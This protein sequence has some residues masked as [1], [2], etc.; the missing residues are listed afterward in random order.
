M[1]KSCDNVRLQE[2]THKWSEDGKTYTM[3]NILGEQNWK[4]AKV[5]VVL[6][7]HWDT[8]PHASEESDPE[9]AK[10]PILGANDGASGVAVLLELARAV[11]GRLPKDLGVLYL[12]TDGEDLGPSLEEMFLGAVYFSKHLPDPKPNYGILLDM[13]GDRELKIPVEPNSYFYAQDL[14][15]VFYRL[16]GGAGFRAAFPT[17][18]GPTIEDDHLCLNQVGVPTMDLIDFDY[19]PSHAWWHTGEDTVD[20]CSA[21]SLGTVGK[22]LELWLL[23]PKPWARAGWLG[24]AG[25]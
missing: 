2:L 7:A 9:K 12:M 20:K 17:A 8:R 16:V 25:G 18:Y 11:K 24:G 13:I 10:K 23:Q 4:D 22:A 5:R 6:L 14:C 1:K 3:W 19:G 21:K 15:T